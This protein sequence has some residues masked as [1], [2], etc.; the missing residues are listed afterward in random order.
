[1]DSTSR[2]RAVGVRRGCQR[3][4]GAGMAVSSLAACSLL[5][6]PL[7]EGA[8][9]FAPPAVYARWWQMTETCSGRLG[10]FGA[11]KWYSVPGSE[12][13]RDGRAASGYYDTRANRIV[14][15]QE[16]M[17][18]GP[19]VRH[20]MIHA[21]LKEGG[22]P[23]SV[24]LGAC[25]S[26]VYCQGVC[27]E[28]AGQWHAPQ[29]DY[30]MLPPESL[31]VESRAE[32]LPRE[33]DGQ[34]FLAL[35]ITVQNLRARAVLLAATADGIT[36]RTFGYD[37]RGP[38]GGTSGG[39]VATD[40]STLFFN[41]FEKKQWLFE[42]RV[43]SHFGGYQLLPGTYLVRGSFARHDSPYESISLDP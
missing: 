12:F 43:P 22:H 26:L 10:E 40:S 27:V 39:E 42:F 25:A 29:K 8:K 28:D 6:A 1:V 19:V 18:V 5:T 11:I 35:Q 31:D 9:P 32:L 13:L 21:L 23:R 4:F 37:L 38:S 24:F 36:P 41:P 2:Q 34:R 16:E 7:P 17:E 30:L 15:A 14:V 33:S 3:V 20:E